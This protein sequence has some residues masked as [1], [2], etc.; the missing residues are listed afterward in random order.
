VE[1]LFPKKPTVY[2]QVVTILTKN[3]ATMYDISN[4]GP[5]C[6]GSGGHR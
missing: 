6:C 5:C 1:E 4:N 2:G 3:F